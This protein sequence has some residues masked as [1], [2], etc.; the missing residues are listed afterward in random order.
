M[1][2]QKTSVLLISFL[3]VAVAVI[4]IL[5]WLYAVE[6]TSYADIKTALT[7]TTATFG[8]LLGIITAGLMFTQGKFSELSSE[9]SEKSPDYLSSVLPLEK[10][11]SIE[12]HLLMLR[13][14]FTQLAA[15][16]T[17]AEE[18]NLYERIIAKASLMFVD[19][20]TISNLKLRQQGLPDTSLLASEMDLSLYKTYEK[21]RKSVKKEWQL[22]KIIG[23]IINTWEAPTSFLNEKSKSE[24]ALQ[25]DLKSCIAILKIK[26][27]IDKN[28]TNIR[29]E[30][31]ET[32]GDLSDE[33]N[34]VG[35]RLH[36][37]RIHQ[38]SSQ[39]EH[40]STIRGKYFYTAIIFITTPLLINLLILPFFSEI[41]VAFF[42]PIISITSALSV[43]GVVFLLLYIH[44][45]LNV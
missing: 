39:M 34:E 23:R 3:L 43:M 13:K 15:T 44:K 37:D 29:S 21:E 6:L 14:A 9:L 16:T 33:I 38:L 19:F 20:A 26:E 41:T 30:A 35:K 40:A 32:F 24:S 10:I 8:T 5:A 12:N 11:Q 45:I 7:T 42:K 36:K 22:F 27:S 1:T 2:Y 28:L 18:R 25:N 31:E 4:F 17:V